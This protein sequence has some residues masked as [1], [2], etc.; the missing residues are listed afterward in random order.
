M[1]R[2]G[3]LA[4][5]VVAVTLVACSAGGGMTVETPGAPPSGEQGIVGQVFIGPMCPV[6]QEGLDCPD[7]P[8]QA[9]LTVLDADGRQVGQ[10]QTDP[11]GRFQVSLEPGDYMLRPEHGDGIAWAGEMPVTVTQG[12][13]TPVTITYDSGIR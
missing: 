3:I 13:Y 7:R 4:A 9:T 10:F 1:Y 6:V 5:A 11:G 12:L 2:A 8:Y